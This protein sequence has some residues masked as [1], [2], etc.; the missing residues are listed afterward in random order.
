[1]PHAIPSWHAGITSTN[2][3]ALPVEEVMGEV[4][5]ALQEPPHAAVLVAP[6]G[7]GKTTAV[8]L[9]VLEDVEGGV[10]VTEPRRV[11]ARAAASRMS[12]L[13]GEQAEDSLFANLPGRAHFA[14]DLRSPLG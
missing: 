10:L 5:E 1:M 4:L 14:A 7:A 8:P 9:A 2:E 6:P 11:A 13:R 12:A 3:E